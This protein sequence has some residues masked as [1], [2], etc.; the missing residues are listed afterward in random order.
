MEAPLEQQKVEFHQEFINHLAIGGGD[1]PV[2]AGV[3]GSLGVRDGGALAHPWFSLL[4]TDP[5]AAVGC[6]GLAP[7]ATVEPR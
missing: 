1:H 3:E 7:P 2:T 5:S 4:G 6:L